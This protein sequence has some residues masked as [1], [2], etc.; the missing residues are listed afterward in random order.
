M[1]ERI[2]EAFDL[3]RQYAVRE[4][5]IPISWKD[6]CVGPW[7]IRVNGT[8]EDR[9]VP[10]YHALIERAVRLRD[11]SM[12]TWLYWL[13]A[14]CGVLSGVVLYRAQRAGA[15]SRAWLRDQARRDE[16]EPYGS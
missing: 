7:R 1:S 2:S 10:P 4:G 3:I 9:G 13:P 15:M 6:W 16:A 8:R 11:R 5:W 14:V 12:W